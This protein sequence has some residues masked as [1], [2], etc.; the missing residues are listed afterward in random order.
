MQKRQLEMSLSVKR[1]TSTSKPKNQSPTAAY[2]T[3]RNQVKNVTKSTR[4]EGPLKALVVIF[5]P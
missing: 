3:I 4:N 1:R 5:G 2:K